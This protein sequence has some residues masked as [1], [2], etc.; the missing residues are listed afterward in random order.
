MTVKGKNRVKEVISA[1]WYLVHMSGWPSPGHWPHS[2][3]A[4]NVPTGTLFHSS[5]V[6]KTYDIIGTARSTLYVI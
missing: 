1:C 2:T 6:S 4:E 5:R 3:A